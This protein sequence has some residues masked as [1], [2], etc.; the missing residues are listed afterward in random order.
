MQGG[1]TCANFG[2]NH[3]YYPIKPKKTSNLSDVSRDRPFFDS[4][5][6]TLISGYSLGRDDMPQVGNLPLEQL[7]FGR[8][9][10]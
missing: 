7:T 4:I 5:Y 10:F 1:I 2:M 9:E 3:L 6:F 8:F